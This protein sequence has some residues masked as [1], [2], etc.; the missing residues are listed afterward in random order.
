MYKPG[1]TI[2]GRVKFD[3]R[4]RL[5]S[6]ALMVGLVCV[7]DAHYIYQRTQNNQ[8]RTKRISEHTVKYKQQLKL[9]DYQDH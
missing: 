6:S 4:E 3:V 5:R 2:T 7:H 1:D 9:L 8:R